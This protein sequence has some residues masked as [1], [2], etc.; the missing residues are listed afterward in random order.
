MDILAIKSSNG[1][2][3][4][5][6]GDKNNSINGWDLLN[7]ELTLTDR[8]PMDYTML[9]GRNAL[10]TSSFSIHLCEF[11]NKRNGLN[12]KLG[13]LHLQDISVSNLNC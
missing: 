10:G 6:P 11:S 1:D 4:R 3:E 9:I 8:G 13:I 5:R 7:V 12:M 2:V